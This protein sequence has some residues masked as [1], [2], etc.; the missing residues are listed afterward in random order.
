MYD[1]YGLVTV[2]TD[3][4]GS[5]I[6]KR[7]PCLSYMFKKEYLENI[8]VIS[9]TSPNTLFLPVQIMS[10]DKHCYIIVISEDA[11]SLF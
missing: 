3:Q 9:P 1:D 10:W 5:C 2:T 6:Y 4:S 11:W 7:D 8:Y